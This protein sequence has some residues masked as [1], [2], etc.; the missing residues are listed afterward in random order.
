MSALFPTS[1]PLAGSAVTTST[2][3]AAGHTALHN[4]LADEVRALATKL[5]VNGSAVTT[6]HDYKLSGVTG[7]DKATSLAGI[8]TLTNK[9]LSSPTINTPAITNPTITGGGSWAGSP[10]ISTPTITSPTIVDFG[11]ATHSHANP[12]GGGQLGSS[13]LQTNAVQGHQLATNAITLGY[14]ERTTA[15]TTTT[16]GS[17]VDV[18]SLSVT[19]TVPSGGRRI[20]VTGYAEFISS[21][22][23][24]GNGVNGF[25]LEDGTEIGR[26]AHTTPVASYSE[27]FTILASKVA[28]AGSHTYKIQIQQAATGTITLSAG[29]TYPAFILVELV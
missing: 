28:S 20:K 6:T 22:Q 11:N 17:G 9:T 14:A 4:N 3:S 21:S 12:G 24:A 1:L 8:E 5:G 18:T 23:A 10:T 15:F 7:S 19:V 16:V 2:L 26:Y 27:P 13:A 29:S 25:I